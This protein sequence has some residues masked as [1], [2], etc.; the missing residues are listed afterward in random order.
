M[1][2]EPVPHFGLPDYTVSDTH[3]IRR[4]WTQHEIEHLLNDEESPPDVPRH[5]TLR[6]AFAEIVGGVEA[7]RHSPTRTHLG[8][9]ASLRLPQPGGPYA[10]SINLAPPDRTP[11][12][13]MAVDTV[14]SVD[15]PI[16]SVTR[17]G[18]R[19]ARVTHFRGS[20]KGI[21]IVHGDPIRGS[22]FSRE[23]IAFLPASHRRLPHH[24]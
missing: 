3:L 23:D 14:V 5:D 20:W 17:S 13:A 16:V 2:R 12:W 9:A 15:E 4:G 7:S 24:Q 11:L 22:E 6:V 19:L 10:R 1:N 21:S 18:A 8:L